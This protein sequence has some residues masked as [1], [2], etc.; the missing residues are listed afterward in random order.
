MSACLIQSRI[1]TRP[2]STAIYTVVVSGTVGDVQQSTKVTVNAHQ[3]R[4]AVEFWPH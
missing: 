1:F 4:P 3:E 2:S